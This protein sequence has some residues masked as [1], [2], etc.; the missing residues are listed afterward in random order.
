MLIKSIDGVSEYFGGIQ[1][2]ITYKVWK[3]F[4]R[5]ATQFYLK[6]A[7]GA[8]LLKVLEDKI[9]GNNN[10]AGDASDAEIEL[11]DLL[12]IALVA[13]ADYVG[14][15]RMILSTGDAGKMQN[16][17]VNSQAPAKWATVGS[18]NDAISRGDLAMEDV[19]RYLEA[20]EGQFAAWTESE[21]YT[22]L[23]DNYVDSAEEL[24]YH[25]PFANNAR[26]LYVAMKPELNKA[27]KGHLNRF[28][29]AAA[30][31][32]LIAAAKVAAAKAENDRTVAD[33]ELLEA[34]NR[35]AA[36]VA[37]KA[38][39]DSVAYLNVNTEWRLVSKTDGVQNEGIL[40]DKRRDEIRRDIAA[41]L[42]LAESEL[43]SYL[44]D[45]ASETVLPTYYASDL[46]AARVVTPTTRF[47]NKPD[48]KYA[49]L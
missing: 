33:K 32:E 49:V 31:A 18:L 34:K 10:I 28:M 6:P 20:N 25:Y 12:R 42:Q 15:F 23:K 7:I 21:F 16:S 29:G 9:D 43:R 3:P 14:T 41:E 5:E 22:Q 17:P 30:N 45:I 13:Y 1:R 36:V 44:Q 37:L 47:E 40:S 24:T 8:E 26:R 19:L 38:V 48:R 11:I 35:A 4:L 2:T 27:Q 39:L 46:Y